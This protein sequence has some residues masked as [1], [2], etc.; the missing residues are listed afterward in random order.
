MKIFIC[1]ARVDKPFCKEFVRIIDNHQVYT[2]D[3]FYA[4]DD[5]WKIILQR[6]AW[7]DVLVFLISTH[8]LKSAYCKRELAIALKHKKKIVPILLDAEAEPHIPRELAEKNWADMTGALTDDLR[9]FVTASLYHIEQEL[10]QQP[11]PFALAA[12]ANEAPPYMIGGDSVTHISEANSLIAKGEFDRAN[13]LLQRLHTQRLPPMQRQVVDSLIA[14]NEAALDEMTSER[15]R[16]VDYRLVCELAGNSSVRDITL[17]AYEDFRKRFPDYDPKNVRQ[18]LFGHATPPRREAAA[19][20]T[21]PTR[22]PL[23]RKP[24][25][26]MPLLEFLPVHTVHNMRPFEMAKYPVTNQ[27]FNQFISDPNGAAQLRWW[28]YSDFALNY[29]KKS[30]ALLPAPVSDDLLPRLAC[31]Y[32][33]LAFCCYLRAQTGRKVLLPTRAQR[34][35]AAQGTDGRLYP[36][37]N[38]LLPTSANYRDSG[39]GHRTPVTH[40]TAV[41]PYGLVDMAGN[42]WE[43][44]LDGANLERPYDYRVQADRYLAGGSYRS[45]PSELRVDAEMKQPPH[46][47]TP[48]LGFRVVVQ[49]ETPQS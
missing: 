26:Y 4:G 24:D 7:C 40:Y 28:S 47:T 22:P 33:A 15:A 18:L 10:A 13:M 48:T 21:E 23:E 16:D 3:R 27:Q 49:L 41:S 32:D 20:R 17:K 45:Q 30:S 12:V 34:R 29:R 19:E 43:W 37:G 44:L 6:L 9:Q 35:R 31:W 46:L 1:Y 38:E 8:S 2:D 25:F 36:S 42:L 11:Q 39:I 5:W 14:F